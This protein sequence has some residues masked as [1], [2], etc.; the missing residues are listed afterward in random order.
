MLKNVLKRWGVIIAAMTSMSAMAFAGVTITSPAPGLTTGSPVHFVAAA[1]SSLPISAITVYVDNAAVTT[2]NSANLDTSI[3]MSAGQH[4]VVVQAWDSA[5]AVMK[6]PETIN[7]IS[8]GSGVTVSSPTPNSATGSP[9]HV[10]ASAAA[11]GARPIG[12]M[13]IYLDNNIV[14]TINAASVNANINAGAGSHLLVVQAWDSAGAVYKNSMTVSVGGASTKATTPPNAAVHSAIQTMPAWE[15]CTVC[16]GPNAQGPVAQYAMGE[17]VASPSLSGQAA[18]FQIS[19]STPYADAI[20]WKQLGADNS[21]T[22]FQYDLDFYLT[23]PQ[24]AQA[25]EFDANQSIGN[26]KFIFGTQCNIKGDG[27]WDVWDT[28]GS[29]WRSTGIA[30]AMPTAFQWHHLTWQFY[31]DSSKIYFVAVTLDGVTHYVNQSYSARPVNASEVNVAFQMDGD[32][33]MHPYSAWL[34]NVTLTAW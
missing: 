19:G 34:D 8:G 20:W 18:Q 24:L 6:S 17:H 4:Y 2:V 33:G 1:S 31:R 15:S 3:P 26:L 12:T 22:H 5:G 13:T 10:V 16:A 25:L 30:C 11:P 7:V 9:L 32:Y 29:A 14:Y 21:K 27:A 23:Q 28:A